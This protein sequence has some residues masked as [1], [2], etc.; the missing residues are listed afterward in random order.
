MLAGHVRIERRIDEHPPVLDVILEFQRVGPG[1]SDTHP[2][3]GLIIV[4]SAW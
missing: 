1:Q 3:R 2:R 4:S